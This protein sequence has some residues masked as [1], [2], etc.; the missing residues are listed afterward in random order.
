METPHSETSTIAGSDHLKS[1][2]HSQEGEAPPSALPSTHDSNP[3]DRSFPFQST[4][5]A[6]GGYTDEYRAVTKAGFEPADKALRPIPS[7]HA[8]IPSALRDP[9]KA[10]ELKDVK[11]VT[12]V[13]NDVEDPRNY[14]RWYKWC[15]CLCFISAFS[16][17]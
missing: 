4:D 14:A 15:M 5:I 16:S 9:E 1:S 12:F 10:K 11:L 6:E 7:N 2:K 3:G 13:P 17:Y 8:A